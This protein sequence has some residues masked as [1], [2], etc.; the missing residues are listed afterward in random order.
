MRCAVDAAMPARWA[1]LVSDRPSA[2]AMMPS[3]TSPRSSACTE[4]GCC[5]PLSSS[6][7]GK[8]RQSGTACH[9][10]CLACG[11]ARRARP[12]RTDRRIEESR[13]PVHGPDAMNRLPARRLRLL[14]EPCSA[15][16]I[17]HVYSH[18]K[19]W[20]SFPLIDCPR[21][22]IWHATDSARGDE[23]AHA[24]DRRKRTPRQP[25]PSSPRGSRPPTRRSTPP[26]PARPSASATR[27]S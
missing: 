18:V 27:S 4:P 3:R 2:W 20:K 17:S 26:W 21:S 1:M 25:A 14:P 16:A 19:K 10:E 12:A 8:L 7:R 15:C 9:V 24:G 6:V 13:H 22:G 11:R 23:G 5:A